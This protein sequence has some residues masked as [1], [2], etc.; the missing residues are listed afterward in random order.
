MNAAL[1]I[2]WRSVI[3]TVLSWP[4]DRLGYQ[5]VQ[6]ALAAELHV[7]PLSFLL[8]GMQRGLRLVTYGGKFQVSWV[9]RL[10]TSQTQAP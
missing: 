4:G 6:E 1:S 9:C 5:E 8:S 2:F 10:S 3:G 7:A